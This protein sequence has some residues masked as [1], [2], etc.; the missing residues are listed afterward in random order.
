MAK[1]MKGME[2]LNKLAKIPGIELPEHTI[3]ITLNAYFDSIV[4]IKVEY[5][6]NLNLDENGDL[7]SIF[8]EY[9]LKLKD[10]GA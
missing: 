5:Y 6:P 8:K 3:G 4:T 9:E 10:E 7:I 1:I 2:F